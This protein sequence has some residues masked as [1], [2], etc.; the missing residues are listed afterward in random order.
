M[1]ANCGKYQSALKVPSIIKIWHLMSKHGN[2]KAYFDILRSFKGIVLNYLLL[3]IIFP[4][5]LLFLFCLSM[6]VGSAIF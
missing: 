1:V 5:D 4:S 3:L 2:L 6:T